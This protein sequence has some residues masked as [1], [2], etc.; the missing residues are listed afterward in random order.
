[1]KLTLARPEHASVIS[2]F[3]TEVHPEGFDHQEMYSAATVSQ[4]LRD[5]E[6]EILVATANRAV[7]GCGL[8][9]P[10]PWNQS[11]EIGALSVKAIPERAKVGKAIFEALRRVGLQK[12][13]LCLFRARSESAFKR[14]RNV[15]AMCWGYWPIPGTGSL[16][17]AELLMGMFNEQSD[18]PRIQ[19]PDN[20]LTRLP[21]ATRVIN[22]YTRA[23]PGLPYPKNYPVGAPR[24]TGTPVISGR[25][26]PTYHSRENYLTIESSAGPY[27]VEIIRAFVDKVRK[28]GVT[29]I[30][31]TLPV[32]QDH[33][34]DALLEAGFRPTAYLPGWFLRG[35]YRYDCVQMTSGIPAP[36][37]GD[38][39]FTT[40][41]VA[42]I[43]DGFG[44]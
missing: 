18:S 26:W 30:R 7:I 6:I 28:K 13:G 29:D 3:Y 37:A 1:M 38:S 14:G 22:A 4:L 40:R 25:V 31:L 44:V 16:Q 20:A 11:L 8:G 36:R 27:P 23:E 12:Y 19:P 43:S 42:K 34:Y 24:G 9:L 32:N 39:D 41:V 21:F 10:R 15:G 33:V 5:G 2:E 17:N 35:P